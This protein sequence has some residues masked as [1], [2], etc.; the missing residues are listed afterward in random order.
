MDDPNPLSPAQSDAYV[1]F[2]ENKSKYSRLVRE[3]ALQFPPPS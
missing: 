2:Q 1:L 3:Q